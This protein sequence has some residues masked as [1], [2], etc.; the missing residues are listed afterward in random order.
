MKN[1]ILKVISFVIIVFIVFS[2]A[3]TYAM[4][5]TEANTS[6]VE[7]SEDYKQWLEL[8]DE[9]KKNRLEPRKYDIITLK[10]NQSYLKEMNNVFRIQQLL[11]ANVSATYDL[12][13][14]IPENVK[15][16]NQMSTNSC[17]AFATIGAVESHLGLRDKKASLPTVAYDFSEKHMNYSTAREAF[18]NNQ[19]NEYGYSK[20]VSDGGNAYLAIQYMASG[21]GLV[22]ESDVPF[23]N[24]EEDIDISEIQNKEVQTT[25]YDTI[26]FPATYASSREEIMPSIKEHI[27]NYGG[28]YAGVHGA[29]IF[30][31]AYNNET[32][33][34][35]CSNTIFYPMDHAVTIIGWDDNYSKENFNEANRP[36]ENGAWIIK[37][38]W[39]DFLTE[40]LATIKEMIFEQYQSQC[41]SN[42]WYSP[43]EIENDFVLDT[44]KQSYGE[45]KV[46]IQGED[47]VIEYGNEG[48][49]YISYEDCNIYKNLTGIE[50]IITGKDFDTVYQ[51]DLLGP[52]QSIY[53]TTS[54]ALNLANVF[55]RDDS[56]QEMLEKISV[57]TMEGYECK[58]FVNP[59]GSSKAKS[60]LQEVTLKDGDTETFEAGFHTIEFAEP[61]ELT[62]DSFVVVLQLLQDTYSK[63][64]AL[65]S[66]IA[67][68]AWENAV[69]NAGE[70]FYAS[71]TDFENNTWTDLATLEDETL[72]GNLCIKA[73]TTEGASEEPEPVTL[74]EIYI[75]N[76]PAKTEYK[77]GENFDKTG[78]RVMARY[79]DNSTKEITNYTIVDGNNLTADKTS[80]TIQYTED[81]LTRSVTQPITVTEDT[82]DTENPNPEQPEP[83]NPQE[84]VSSNFTNS[85][86]EI[87]E[88]KLYFNSSNLE[89]VTGEMTIKITGIQK[90][91]ESNTYT[92]QYY[93]SGT[94]GDENITT[95]KEAELVR[96]ND[97][98][99]SITLQIQ[100]EDLENYSEITESENLYVYI[101]EIAQIN[102]ESTEQIVTLNV[103]NQS[104]PQCYVDGVYVGGIDDV[105]NHGNNNS[106]N[107]NGNDN[108]N[109]NSN[110]GNTNQGDDNTVATG[111]LPYAGG[112]TF[113][114]VLAIAIIVFGGFA[115]YRYKNIDR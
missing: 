72:R 106:N 114:V 107:N 35:Y 73:Y 31:D 38:S 67:D 69:V 78:M 85:K 14:I 52:S 36:Q 17:W 53:V 20:E 95:W 97:G 61:I 59:N 44:Y 11:R 99:Y 41:E 101:K 30:S 113:K 39:G 8:S 26:E 102:Q 109:G 46:S 96:E 56:K 34:I 89:D 92:Y 112:V 22:N 63:T 9:E 33:A 27:V 83:E 70:S 37:N 64:F 74:T 65:E 21:L 54:D 55:T 90:G 1:R 98:T 62:G 4:T 40:K 19:I 5:E 47:I 49:M 86:T 111:K 58:V 45:S 84:P 29:Q 25:L 3:S 50:K 110:N 100:S 66:N 6:A 12:K 28:I 80:V 60:D 79:S 68:S 51:N 87:T 88:S 91:D 16:R 76:G 57:Y 104:E 10:D 93:I 77:E 82:T 23:V 48:Y 105:L 15:I 103:K 115:F 32:G 71:E 24:S 94:Q 18:L 43:E 42:G 13:D 81:G 108:N 2:F 7:Y 75:E